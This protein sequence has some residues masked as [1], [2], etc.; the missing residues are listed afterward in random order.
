MKLLLANKTEIQYEKTSL[1][2]YNGRSNIRIRIP[3]HDARDKNTT[4]CIQS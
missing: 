3:F 4:G 2:L 1:F